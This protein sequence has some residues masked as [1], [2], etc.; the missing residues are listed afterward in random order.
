MRRYPNR[1][2]LAILLLLPL[3]VATCATV[4]KYDKYESSHPIEAHDI[5]CGDCHKLYAADFFSASE[6]VEFLNKH[7]KADRPKP[8]IMEGIVEYILS[9]AQT[10]SE[11]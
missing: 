10:T 4:S 9:E 11:E 3:L 2:T 5:I 1:V 8:E 7:P 6:W